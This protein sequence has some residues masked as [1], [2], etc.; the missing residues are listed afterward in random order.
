MNEKR[1]FCDHGA[2]QICIWT[3]DGTVP[4]MWD[5]VAMAL[6]L[7][8]STCGVIK[9]DRVL[10]PIGSIC[11]DIFCESDR[12]ALILRRLQQ[13]STRW[14]WHAR[15]HQPFL[16]RHPTGT[17]FRGTIPMRNTRRNTLQLEVEQAQF[18]KDDNRNNNNDRLATTPL[19]VATLNIH[20]AKKKTVD[21]QYLLRTQRCDAI[22]LQETL[23]CS[24]D[25]GI[26]IPN[27]QCFS[28]LGHTAAARP[29]VSV[30]RC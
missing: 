11:F 1:T 5:R 14:G 9:I 22:A 15:Y 19:S 29:G 27:Y 4:T 30:S 26:V 12:S 7:P 13:I 24:T 21:L 10:Q 23:L 17:D 16:A 6:G 18:P 3:L 2:T 28:A 25:F 20:G 8:A